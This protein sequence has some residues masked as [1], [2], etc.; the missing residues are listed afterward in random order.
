MKK[1]EKFLLTVFAY[2][3]L[4]LVGG[5]GV[6]YAYN[7]YMAIREEN[8]SLSNRI[9]DMNYAISKGTE[10]AEKYNWIEEHIPVFP[11]MKKLHHNC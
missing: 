5:G 6:K 8:E 3:F 7:H 2:A 11:A 9:A 4:I 10:W 1:S